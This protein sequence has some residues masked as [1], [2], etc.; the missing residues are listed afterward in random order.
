M[1]FKS[2][3]QYRLPNFDYSS[4]SAYFITI[5]T[6]DRSC[7]FGK[8]IDEKMYLTD[9]GLEVERLLKNAS[10]KLE[11]LDISD[12]VVMPDHLHFIAIIN[13]EN[14]SYVQP[15]I[16]IA[17]LIPK[18]ISSFANHFKGRV[19]KWCKENNHPQF[20]WTSRFN[21]RIIRDEAEYNSKIHY[22][23]N[24]VKN[25]KDDGSQIL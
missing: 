15:P 18:S 8:I 24:N 5:V 14:Y 6:K 23:K 11:H 7:D 17:P 3:K 4:N 1:K 12:F 22:I 2:H 16:G 25:W 21:D 13:V 20:Q 10:E 19:T 9:I